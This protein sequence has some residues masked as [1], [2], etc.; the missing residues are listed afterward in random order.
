MK[1]LSFV[2]ALIIGAAPGF[3]TS[4]RAQT[5]A[6]LQLGDLQRQAIAADPRTRELALLD[7]QTSLR[8]QN[9]SA[10]RLPAINV[11]G[12]AQYQTD[13]PTAPFTVGGR[14]VFTAPKK[15]YDSYF[16][17]EQRLFD[18]TVTAQAAVERAQ[19]AEQ[20]ARVRAAVFSVRQQVHE[21]FF[22]AALLDQRRNILAEAVNDLTS[23]LNDMRARVREGAAIPADA[24]IIEA[25]LLQRQQEELQVWADRRS[26]FLRLSVL[27]GREVSD[28][29]RLALPAIDAAVFMARQSPSTLRL[30]P[31][32]EQFTRTRERLARQAALTTATSAPRVSAFTRVGYGRPGLNFLRDEFDTYAVAG[33]RV[34]WNAWNWGSSV[35]EREA[36]A[37]QQEIVAAEDAAFSRGI[38]EAFNSDQETLERLEAT[39][40]LDQ[41]IIALREQVARATVARVTEH[42]VTMA[43]YLSRDAELLQARI[44]EATHRVELAQTG[45]RLLINLG[46]E[47]P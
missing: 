24:A 32:F 15:T 31:E 46:V 21:A 11:E 47:V 35:R 2:L 37:I 4:A 17:V 19:L 34:Q 7:M 29:N 38:I 33:V 41:R 43:E 36:L 20:Q 18:P 5:R 3:A 9:I 13:V 28:D 1:P 14:S 10:L 12:Q 16:R 44:T 23:R 30:R 25:T 40:E 42:V 26:A 6:P 27:V 45:A 8:L 39:L 22:A